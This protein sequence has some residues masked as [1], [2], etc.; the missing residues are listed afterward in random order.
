MTP[1]HPPPS[2][3]TETE[4][5]GGLEDPNLPAWAGLVI[6]CY[7]AVEGVNALLGDPISDSHRWSA[8]PG[9]N[10]N[11]RTQGAWFFALVGF[12]LYLGAPIIALR[13][14]R[15]ALRAPTRAGTLTWLAVA[16]LLI[17]VLAR[18]VHLGLLTG[19]LGGS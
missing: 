12:W 3:P 10:G 1:A 18:L 17:G 16:A 8:T 15:A 7:A 13:A 4:R 2:A 9:I 5:E 14:G 6:A 19:A 11:Y